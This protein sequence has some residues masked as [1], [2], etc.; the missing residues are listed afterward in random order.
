MGDVF[1]YFFCHW[2]DCCHKK[3]RTWYGTSSSKRRA[4]L[5]TYPSC[6]S[7]KP[8]YTNERQEVTLFTRVMGYFLCCSSL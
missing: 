4:T 8:N 5:V 6:V 2:R 3:H 7:P 1:M